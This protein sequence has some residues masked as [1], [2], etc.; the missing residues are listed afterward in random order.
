MVCYCW[1]AMVIS[2]F[3]FSNRIPTTTLDAFEMVVE[4][5][6]WSPKPMQQ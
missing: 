3:N 4:V 2:L 6:S 1:F 5:N